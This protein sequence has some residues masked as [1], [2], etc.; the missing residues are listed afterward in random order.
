LGDMKETILL[1]CVSNPEVRFVFLYRDD[2]TEFALDTGEI[3]ELLDGVPISH[4]EVIDFL[5]RY[6]DEHL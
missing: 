3:R 1:L 6:L 4:P 5:E 2:G